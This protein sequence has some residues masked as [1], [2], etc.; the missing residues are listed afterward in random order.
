[1]QTAARFALAISLL[2]TTG[3]AA[4]S[5]AVTPRSKVVS[6]MSTPKTG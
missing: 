6:Q 5:H 4:R 2:V 1:M 3:A